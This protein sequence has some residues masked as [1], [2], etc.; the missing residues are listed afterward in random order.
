MPTYI[1]W[2]VMVA[3]GVAAAAAVCWLAIEMTWRA[4]Q[5]RRN[6]AWILEAMR[7]YESVKP[8]PR[9]RFEGTE[10]LS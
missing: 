6:L 4:I 3:G 2:V 5:S 8:S 10:M 9:D 7:H 1:G